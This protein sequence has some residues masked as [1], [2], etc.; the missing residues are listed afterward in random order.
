MIFEEFKED[1][2]LKNLDAAGSYRAVVPPPAR[3]QVAD[4]EIDYTGLKL[5]RPTEDV[6]N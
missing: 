5:Q 1:Q 4:V 3:R 2:P 6:Y